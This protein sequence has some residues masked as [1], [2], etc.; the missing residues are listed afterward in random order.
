MS[1]N[2]SIRPTPT[3]WF[4]S[5]GWHSF[6]RR[7]QVPSTGSLLYSTT[8]SCCLFSLHTQ[9]LNIICKVREWRRAS[10]WQPSR[11]LCR[12]GLFSSWRIQSSIHRKTHFFFFFVHPPPPPPSNS[13]SHHLPIAIVFFL[14]GKESFFFFRSSPQAL[15]AHHE[16]QPDREDSL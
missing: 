2:E 6:L 13:F 8:T 11:D 10:R 5:A 16:V 1:R 12:C 7:R 4:T 14:A 15:L 9:E 3:C